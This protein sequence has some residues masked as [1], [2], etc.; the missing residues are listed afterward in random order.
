[1]DKTHRISE[2]ENYRYEDC[3]NWVTEAVPTASSDQMKG[4]AKDASSSLL[5]ELFPSPWD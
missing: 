4:T 3:E 1:M 2:T 5:L